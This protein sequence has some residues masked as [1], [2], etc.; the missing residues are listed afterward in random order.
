MIISPIK[1]DLNGHELLVRVARKKDAKTIVDFMRKIVNETPYLLS[2]PKEFKLT[3][4]QEELFIESYN[5]S[6]DSIFLLGFLDGKHVG[7]C[8]M[9]GNEKQRLKHRA[10]LS[11]SIYQEYTRKGIGSVMFEKLIEIAK[12]SGKEQLELEVI[13]TNEAALALYKKYGFEIYGEYEN[14]MKYEDGTY[15]NCFWMMKK[16]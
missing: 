16:L 8:S 6:L 3:I 1:Y 2:E 10:S 15:V 5:N 11:I 14:Y 4:K 12:D 9:T 13:S 7:I